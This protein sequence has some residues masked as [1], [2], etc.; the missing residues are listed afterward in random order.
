[1]AKLNRKQLI[2]EAEAQTKAL[3]TIKKWLL[4]AIRISTFGIALVCFSFLGS[5]NY[6]TI[7]I[8]GTVCTF[9]SILAAILINLGIKRGTKN[10]EKIL[11]AVEN[12]K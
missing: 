6:T 8:I 1:M 12:I 7:G 4:Y 5:T 10:V 2:K 11:I 3:M 9:L